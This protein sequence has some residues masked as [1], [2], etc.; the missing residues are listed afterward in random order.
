MS[1]MRRWWLTGLV[2]VWIVALGGLVVWS[3][4][5]DRAT[6]PEQRDIDLALTDLERAAGV[7]YAA[8]GG[9]DRA[10]VLGELQLTRDCRITPVR[11]GLAAARAVTV[12]VADTKTAEAV[13][14]IAAGLPA[15]WATDWGR[16]S[17]GTRV[18]LHA[19]AGNFVGID[20]SSP[21]VATTFTLRLTTGCRPLDGEAPREAGDAPAAPAPALL[22]TVVGAL[23]GTVGEPTVRT[24][25]CPSG[26]VAGSWTVTGVSTPDDLPGHLRRAGGEVV[27]AD[28]TVRAYRNR[29]DSVVVRPEGAQLSVTVSTSCS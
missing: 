19:D 21:A 13:E 20:L 18:S 1:P 4:D 15:D 26:S 7:V 3:V 14:Q 23:G 9:D 25:T 29:D 22:N 27:H 28:E 5:H 6:V 11:S 24:V 12:Y 8:A 2:G 10:V 16:S 17:A